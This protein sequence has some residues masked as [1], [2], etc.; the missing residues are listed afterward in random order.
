MIPF[1]EEDVQHVYIK[2]M[3]IN[4]EHLFI[5]DECNRHYKLDLHSREVQRAQS[6]N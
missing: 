1:K 3:I 6:K 2:S 5:V 4:N